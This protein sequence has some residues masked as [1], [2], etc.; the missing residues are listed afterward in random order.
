MSGVIM[1]LV[2]TIFHRRTPGHVL[3]RVLG[4]ST[5]LAMAAAPIGMLGVG[6]L[7]E[8]FGPRATLFFLAGSLLVVWLFTTRSRALR[9]LDRQG[10]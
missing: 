7:T 9:T 4:M 5:S 6:V 10:A 8:T 2:N 1:P 3:A